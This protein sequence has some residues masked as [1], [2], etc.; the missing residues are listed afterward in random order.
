MTL[1]PT[2]AFTFSQVSSGI[3]FNF[4]KLARA[5]EQV[6]TGKRIL[7]P[8]DDPVSTSIAISLRRQAGKVESYLD[9]IQ[10]SRPLLAT[11]T[12]ELEQASG[13]LT[14]TRAVVLQALNGTLS[15][16]DRLSL[17]NQ[18]D[19]MRD[20]LMGIAN[21]RSG[22]R[23]L[24]S[25]TATAT[26]PYRD[27]TVGNERSA[28]YN[29]NDSQQRVLIGLGVEVQVN[30][31]GS[32][33]F[34]SGKFKGISF[35]GL[36]GVRPGSSA[37]S[38]QGFDNLIV[39]HDAT[40]DALGGG[41]AS[42]SGGALDT[43]IGTHTLNVDATNG[44]VQLGSGP[45]RPIPDISVPGAANFI[46]QDSDGSLAHIDFSGWTG[47]DVSGSLT[48]QGSVSIDGDSFVSFDGSETDLEVVD[49]ETDS[50]LHLD[51]RQVSR[52]GR[53]LV[54]FQGATNLFDII[55]GIAQD[56]RNSDGLDHPKLAARIQQRL[57]EF[58]SAHSG[59]LVGLGQL[60]ARLER[61]E[62]AETRLQGVDLHLQGLISEEEDVDLAQV[63]LEMTR[64]E[65]TLN[66]AQ[67][68]GAR[69][70]QNTLLR[71]LG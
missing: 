71:Y 62:S 35:S 63:V 36:T 45:P 26:E 10:S 46:V 70:L 54:T 1:R 11:A 21:T 52:S 34:A 22:S 68:T 29:G 23:Y 47:A 43:I 38:G 28:V 48:G 61:L 55:G 9:S 44:T 24:F 30:I 32:D 14:D 20:T 19:L 59:L 49:S 18:L 6:A 69:L 33:L 3:E 31:G 60:G 12:S 64:A 40:V 39:R 25:G 15:D 17:A 42:A 8:S 56:L 5:Q 41:L 53:E 65:Q 57:E 58:D 4:S 66:V 7:R 37:N 2:Q 50:V 16:D 27:R 51:M 67:A 13:L